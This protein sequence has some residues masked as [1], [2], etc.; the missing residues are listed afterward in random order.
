MV[1][2]V[3]VWNSDVDQCSIIT[4]LAP[5]SGSFFATI[6]NGLDQELEEGWMMPSCNKHVLKLLLSHLKTLRYQA[7]RPGRDRSTGGFNVVGD[8]MLHM[9]VCGAYLCQCQ[10][11]R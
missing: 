1:D 3:T 11:F 8:V 10:K 2:G 7:S 5:V 6:C 9:T 4:T